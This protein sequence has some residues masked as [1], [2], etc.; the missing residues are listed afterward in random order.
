MNRAR[1][2]LVGI[3]FAPCLLATGCLIPYAYP[4]LDYVPS[5]DLG[6]KTTDVH[7]FRVDVTARQVDIGEDGFIKLTEI[8]Q[9]AD[10]SFPAQ[11][12]LSLERGVYVAGVALNF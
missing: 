10:G 12:K 9:R 4:K 8:Q 7:A 2:F 6:A 3:L 11:T 5:T 1:R